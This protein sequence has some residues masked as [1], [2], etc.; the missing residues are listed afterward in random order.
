M[1]EWGGCGGGGGVGLLCRWWC[2]LGGEVNAWVELR[3]GG[4]GGCEGLGK[5]EL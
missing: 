5:M 4:G 2:W 1:I 3:G